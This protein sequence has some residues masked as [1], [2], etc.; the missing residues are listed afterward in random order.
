[1][2]RVGK[3]PGVTQT[4][5][6]YAVDD[7]FV[8]V[9]LPGYGYAQAPKKV[10]ESWGPMIET[11]LL[12]REALKAVVLLIDSRHGPTDS[13]MLL[14]EWLPSIEADRIVV[15]TKWDKVKKSQR[16][17]RQAEMERELGV[18]V[19]PYSSVDGTGKGQLIG[20]FKAIAVSR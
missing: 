9:D 19:I 17:K 11:Y 3:R 13:D 8:L 18:E 4:I 6:F 5:N 12:N 15:A 16:A 7:Q 14:W 20:T 1:M 10:R 2:A